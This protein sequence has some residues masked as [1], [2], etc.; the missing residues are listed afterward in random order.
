M[1]NQITDHLR[2]DFSTGFKYDPKVNSQGPFAS[3][4]LVYDSFS[5]LEIGVNG[6]YDQ[7]T[8]RGTDSTFTQFGVFLTWKL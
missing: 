5:N 2:Y 1:V 4:E 3:L 8:A 7:E 6:E